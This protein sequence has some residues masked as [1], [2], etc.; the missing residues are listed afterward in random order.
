[1][2]FLSRRAAAALFLA[3]AALALGTGQR[4]M[5]RALDAL[6]CAGKA[7]SFGHG[8]ARRWTM[9]P[10]PGFATTLLLPAPLPGD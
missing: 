4:T 5:Q 3:P 1:M 8:R 10:L 7:Q 2:T 6:A 9:P